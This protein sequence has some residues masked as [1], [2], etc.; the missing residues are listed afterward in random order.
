MPGG[1]GRAAMAVWRARPDL[2]DENAA[3]QYLKP[4]WPSSPTPGH[5]P[6]VIPGT[7]RPT[8]SK[9]SPVTKESTRTHRAGALAGKLLTI[10]LMLAPSAASPPHAG[11]QSLSLDRDRSRQMLGIIKKDLRDN[12]YDPTFRGMS[13]D[14]RFKQA[15]E[16]LKTAESRGQ[17]FGIIAQVLIELEDSHTYFVPPGRTARV[18]YGWRMQ[19][20][21]DNCYVIAVRPGS[22]AEAKGLK[23]GDLLIKAGG[24]DIIRDNLFKFQYL[25]N[26]LRPQ[27]GMRVVVQSPGGAPRELELMAKVTERKL[28]TDLGSGTEIYNLIREEEN[29]ARLNRHRYY[30]NLDGVMIWKMPQF[31]LTKEKVDDVMGKARKHQALILDLRGNGGG[32]EET[33]LRLLGNLF[34]QEVN[35]G[36]LKRRKE[37]KPLVAKSRGA[38]AFE[39]KLVVLVDSESGSAAELLARVVQIEKRGVVIGDRTAGAVMRSKG[40]PH[41]MGADIAIFYG[42]S[43]TDADIQMADGKSLERVGVTP[44][45]VRLPSAED[46]AAM[47]DPVLAHAASLVG[48]KLEAEKAGAMFPIEWRKQ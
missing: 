43:I 37:T 26:V 39:G 14:E 1:E 6:T 10:L 7:L 4:L 22:D 29:E 27:P 15:D 38:E 18:D 41:Q 20:V 24:Y 30:E 19:I 23:V 21:G 13:L 9:E 11:A 5:K 45:Q 48:L 33:L 44:D 28:V 47:R 40:Y 31:D 16:K 34:K 8:S 35:V 32:A 12:Y 3:W 42:V 25:Y 46:L 2:P 36:E 17:M